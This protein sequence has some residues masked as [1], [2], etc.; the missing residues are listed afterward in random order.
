MTIIWVVLI[1]SVSILDPE[2]KIELC[3]PFLLGVFMNKCFS[4]EILI[5]HLVV[6][7]FTFDVFLFYPVNKEFALI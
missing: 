3:E 1:V 2:D 7:Y 5:I 6:R 4:F